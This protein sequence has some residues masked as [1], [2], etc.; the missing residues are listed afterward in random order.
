VQLLAEAG[1]PGIELADEDGDRIVADRGVVTAGREADPSAFAAAV[2]E[3]IGR[4]RHWDRQRA[5]VPA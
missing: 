5:T 2:L 3:A 4:H 1:L